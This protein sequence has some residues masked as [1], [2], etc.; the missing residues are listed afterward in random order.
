[1]TS[2]EAESRL[3][4]CSCKVGR[5]AA[6]YGIER[7]GERL[8]YRRRDGAS[9]RDLERVLNEAVLTAALE[10]ADADLF[11][12]V[13][14]VYA[15]LVDDDADPGARAAVR[16]RLSG[17]GIDVDAVRDDFV[18][19]Q[20]IRTHLRDCAGVDSDTDRAISVENARGTI[21]WARARNE[22][23]ID[24]TIERLVESE[25]VAAGDVE[26]THEVRV[27]CADCGECRPA[28][29]FVAEGGC[30]CDG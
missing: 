16:E 7:V 29:E 17:A 30:D 15:A 25:T 12:D 3:Q 23:V 4:A 5:V 24:G 14:E 6:E 8:A 9:L 1:M 13:S 27:A 22:E 26:V 11:G 10:R 28:V 21:E 19:Y 20:T 18:S 2:G